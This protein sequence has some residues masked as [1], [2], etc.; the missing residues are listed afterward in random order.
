MI[1]NPF[2]T[3]AEVTPHE[4]PAGDSAQ[5][6]VRLVAGPGFSANGSRIILDMPAYLG[7]SRPSV[8]DQEDGGFVEVFCSNPDLRYL[9]RSWDMEVADFPTRTKTSFKGMAQR[10]FVIDFLDGAAREGDEILVKWGYT[11]DGFGCGAKVSVLVLKPEFHN[12]IHV[13]YFADG[14]K[15]LPDFGRSFKGYDRPVPDIELPLSYRILP[16]EPERIRVFRRRT[17]GDLAIL[18]RFANPVPVAKPGGYVAGRLG[19]APNGS[20]LFSL[21]SPHVR[22]ASKGLPLQDTPDMSRVFGSLSIFFGD[23]HTHS[24]F[25]NDCIER[26]KQEMT[27]DDLFT[28]ADNVACIDFLAVTDH[29]QPWDIERNKIREDHWALLNDA[30]RKH[31]REGEFLAFAGFE[32]RDKRGDTAVVLN[33]PFSYADIDVPSLVTVNELWQQFKGRDYV[34]IPHFHNG[35]GLEDGEWYSCPFEG[36]EPNIEIYSCH[37]SYENDTVL[38]RHISQIKRFRRDRNAKY[39]LENGFRFG[40][41][42]NSD[43]HKGNVGI[44]G[45]T[46]VYAKELTHKAIFEAYRKRHVYGTTNA[47][48]RLLFTINGALMGSILPNVPGKTVHLDLKGEQPFKSVDIMKNGGRIMRFRPDAIEFTADVPLNDPGPGNWYVR[49]TQIDNHIAYSSPVWFL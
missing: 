1:E 40:L 13:R 8:Y 11:R 21:S 29:H 6:A 12:T 27:P 20:G 18:D 48:I 17:R 23:L 16:R 46:A 47:R 19:A 42:C 14:T 22:V 24:A 43:G 34:T 7:Y 49:A 3:A 39:F 15:G 37:G 2:F 4:I 38:E 28:Y 44:N 30:V 5:I 41:T 33:E 32:Y 25:S 35:G 45:L 36:I 31:D 9:E 26:E 10:V